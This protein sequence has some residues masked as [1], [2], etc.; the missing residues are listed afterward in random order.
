MNTRLFWIYK[1][2]S[3]PEAGTGVVL[4]S[5]IGVLQS[6]L[7]RLRVIYT[8]CSSVPLFFAKPVYCT[9]RISFNVQ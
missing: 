1:K 8:P 6:F 2:K 5:G 9:N 3:R 7:A 4:R